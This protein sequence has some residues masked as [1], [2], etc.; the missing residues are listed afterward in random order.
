MV[1]LRHLRKRLHQLV[2]PEVKALPPNELN[3][4]SKSEMAVESEEI[5][6]F[7]EPLKGAYSHGLEEI[8][9]LQNI[10]PSTIKPIAIKEPVRQVEA[11]QG[12][13]RYTLPID[14]QLDFDLEGEYRSSM[15]AFVVHESIR[16]LNL[17]MHA[18]K[19]LR[20]HGKRLL[21]DLIQGDWSLFSR[22]SGQGHIDE[23]Q[24]KLVEYLGSRPL[25]NCRTVDFEA[26]VR[27]LIPDEERPKHFLLLEKYQLGYLV[28]LTP[29]EN[30][31]VR[32]YSQEQR[33]IC[34]QESL[35]LL[36]EER[37]FQFC[38]SSLKQVADVFLKPWMRARQGVC[39][40]FELMDRLEQVSDSPK[41]LRFILQFL[42]DVYGEG[43]FP[44]H[45]G[46]VPVGDDV[47]CVDEETFS[48][49]CQVEDRA[50]SYFYKK[51][52]AYPLPELISWL[53][54]EYALS[55]KGFSE[56]CVE[57][58]LRTSRLFHAVK[59]EKGQLIVRLA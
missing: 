55:W 52:L 31:E 23:I 19:Y 20:Q 48:L 35:K 5:L 56:G 28:A 43:H 45:R 59:N 53:S 13:D 51:D 26:L 6:P 14:P 8:Y 12:S 25:K 57:K 37:G 11:R 2:M 46:L 49:F 30:A 38:Q 58:I 47:F 1:L 54:R 10:D 42:G 34:L 16:V 7:Q 36:R 50:L 17:S 24:S 33:E 3:L 15:D 4:Y 29:F 9:A 40:R 41:A 44:F 22:G 21:K 32:R 27:S 18:E 39:R